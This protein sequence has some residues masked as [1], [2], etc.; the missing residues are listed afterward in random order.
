[1]ADG[2]E[3]GEVGRSRGLLARCRAEHEEADLVLGYVNGAVELNPASRPGQL[4]GGRARPLLSRGAFL[5]TAAREVGLDQVARHAVD[6]TSGR[7]A[8][9]RQNI[10]TLTASAASLR[11]SSVRERT[12]SFA[13]TCVRW[14]A[15]VRSER[16]SVEATSAFVRPFATRSATRCSAGVRPSAR[17]RP[18][19]AP[20]SSRARSVQPSA[21]SSSKPASASSIASR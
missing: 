11:A 6:A 16:K 12:P 8:R 19:I 13:Y 20:S 10:G 1:D 3:R 21:P 14:L 15:T 18:P 4:L 2:V 7:P 17:V 9:K 5:G